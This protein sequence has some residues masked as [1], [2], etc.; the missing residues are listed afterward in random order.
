MRSKKRNK[1]VDRFQSFNT[2]R[3]QDKGNSAEEHESIDSNDKRKKNFNLFNE[4]ISNNFKENS[5]SIFWKKN[6]N[7]QGKNTCQDKQSYKILFQQDSYS[8]SA[9]KIVET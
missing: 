4:F 1:K 3:T 5:I 9:A 8:S 2:L 7:E 6:W